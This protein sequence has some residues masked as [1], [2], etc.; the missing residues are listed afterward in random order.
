[1]ES[2]VAAKNEK[3]LLMGCIKLF[4]SEITKLKLSQNIFSK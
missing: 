3:V 2:E 1:M 4:I